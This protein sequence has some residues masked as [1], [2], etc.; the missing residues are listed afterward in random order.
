VRTGSA[1]HSYNSDQRFFS[2]PFNQ[3]GQNIA[4]VVP[5]DP[6][7]LV[8]GFYMVFAFNGAGVP[9]TAMTLNVM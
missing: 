4:A 7:V 3:A 6:T 1:T 5:S 9:S 8:P 2:L